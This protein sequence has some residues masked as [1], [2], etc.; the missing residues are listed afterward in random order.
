MTTP[1][2]IIRY[3][4]TFAV[5]AVV[6]A[7][8][9][10][11]VGY[12]APG[13]GQVTFIVLTLTWAGGLVA[14]RRRDIDTDGG[15]LGTFPDPAAWPPERLPYEFRFITRR[16]T[17]AELIERLGPPAQRIGRSLRYDLPAEGVLDILVEGDGGDDRV[18]AIQAYRRKE[19]VPLDPL[20]AFTNVI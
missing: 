6:A 1:E 17:L 10:V 19:N 12:F 9:A 2:R 20:S 8:A 14:V 11:V 4:I 3:A 15:A 16:T 18:R 5:G 7:L 13:F